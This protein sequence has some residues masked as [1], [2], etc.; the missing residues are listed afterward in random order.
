MFPDFDSLQVRWSTQNCHGWSVHCIASSIFEISG[1][2]RRPSSLNLSFKAGYVPPDWQWFA[3]KTKNG[4][5]ERIYTV[6][7]F[8]MQIWE[9]S[10]YH[11]WPATNLS[12]HSSSNNKFKTEG[13]LCFH[14]NCLSIHLCHPRCWKISRLGA[15]LLHHHLLAKPKAIPLPFHYHF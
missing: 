15:T 2:S 13:D 10:S 5:L 3:L 1:L 9:I 4:T 8:C 6:C 11:C 12:F 14:G 7:N